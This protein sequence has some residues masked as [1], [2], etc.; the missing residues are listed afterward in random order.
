MS[1]ERGANSSAQYVWRKEEWALEIENGESWERSNVSVNRVS[2]R[3]SGGGGGGRAYKVFQRTMIENFQNKEKDINIQTPKLEDL[4][5]TNTE[6]AN[7]QE[8]A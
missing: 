7:S 4:Q 6:Q 1:R 8:E 2:G 5:N 3:G